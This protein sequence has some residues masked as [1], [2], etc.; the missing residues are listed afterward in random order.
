MPPIRYEHEPNNHRREGTESA[1]LN[2][3]ERNEESSD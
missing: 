2:T 1:G 3:R